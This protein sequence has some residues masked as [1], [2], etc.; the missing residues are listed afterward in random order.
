ML[1]QSYHWTLYPEKTTIVKTTWVHA[2]PLQSCPTLCNSMDCSL[3]A[4]LS[5]GLSG[6]GYWTGLSFPPPRDLPNPG[7]EPVSFALQVDSLLSQPHNLCGWQPS[8]HSTLILTHSL[9]QLRLGSQCG[10]V[11]TLKTSSITFWLQFTEQNR[12]LS[13]SFLIYRMNVSMDSHFLN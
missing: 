6:Q 1:Q 8:P 10:T 9:A 5:M 3:T 4:S 13:E 2:K 12:T 11:W 7:I